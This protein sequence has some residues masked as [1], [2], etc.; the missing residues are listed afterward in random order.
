[1]LTSKLREQRDDKKSSMCPVLMQD[2]HSVYLFY[3]K[4]VSTVVHRKTEQS[5]GL[6]YTRN[7]VSMDNPMYTPFIGTV[8]IAS[9]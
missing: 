8:E 9:E 5:N 3:S 1:M 2:E 4:Y 7:A 6:G